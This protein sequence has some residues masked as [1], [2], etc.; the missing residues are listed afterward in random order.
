M[1]ELAKRVDEEFHGTWDAAE[2]WLVGS[3]A[4]FAD[5]TYDVSVTVQANV[6]NLQGEDPPPSLEDEGVEIVDPDIEIVEPEDPVEPPPKE[7][8][9]EESGNEETGVQAKATDGNHHSFE[10]GVCDSVPGGKK[11]RN[12]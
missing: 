9:C 3:Y 1:G 4:G 5:G 6:F 12:E 2:L 7:T 8:T 10:D 11:A